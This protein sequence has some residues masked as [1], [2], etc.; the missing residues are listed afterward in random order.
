MEVLTICFMF[1]VGKPDASQKQRHLRQQ[2][3]TVTKGLPPQHV[4][5]ENNFIPYQITITN[6][7]LG[8]NFVPTPNLDDPFSRK[9]TTQTEQ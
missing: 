1:V 8:M 6:T 2:K 7:T 5:N 9:L 3:S 4:T